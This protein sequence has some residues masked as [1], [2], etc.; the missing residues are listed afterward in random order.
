M[1]FFSPQWQ[2][3]NL[4]SITNHQTDLPDNLFGKKL[5]KGSAK[6]GSNIKDNRAAVTPAV[7]AD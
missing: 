5:G 7:R 6:T 3:T 4:T 1:I 2:G